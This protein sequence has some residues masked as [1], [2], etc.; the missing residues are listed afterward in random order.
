MIRLI[1]TLLLLAFE[2][3]LIYLGVNVIVESWS[4]RQQV[5]YGFALLVIGLAVLREVT[6]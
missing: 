6:R 5:G 4:T 3:I 1:I 2:A